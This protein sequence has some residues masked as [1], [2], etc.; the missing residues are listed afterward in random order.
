MSD[1]N[2]ARIRTSLPTVWA[3]I[4]TYAATRLGYVPDDVATELVLVVIVPGAGAVIY[5][6]GRALEH[7]NSTI[8]RLL[9]RALLGSL[10]AP[11][12]P[13]EEPPTLVP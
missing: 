1:R 3:A 9:A 2:I 7:S 8:G 13:I 12:Y 11:S 5:E 10:K 4:V 6:T